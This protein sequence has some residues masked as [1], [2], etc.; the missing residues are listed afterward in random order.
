MNEDDYGLKWLSRARWKAYWEG[1]ADGYEKAAAQK[2]H[3]LMMQ[4]GGFAFG[5]F[6]GCLLGTALA[7]FLLK[8]LLVK[9]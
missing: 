7:A 8:H 2:V 4:T 9:P 3:S 6:I 1:Y 5:L